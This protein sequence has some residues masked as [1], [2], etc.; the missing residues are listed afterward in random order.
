[1]KELYDIVEKSLKE[2]ETAVET[3]CSLAVSLF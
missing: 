2:E 1:M 3:Y